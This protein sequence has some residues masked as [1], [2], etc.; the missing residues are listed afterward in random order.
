[1]A[2][3]GLVVNLDD[4]WPGRRHN[5]GMLAESGLGSLVEKMAVV[6]K[7]FR[8]YG[9]PAYP[10]SVYLEGPFRQS[11]VAFTEAEL[12]FDELMSAVRVSL[13]WEFSEIV[14]QVVF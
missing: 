5:S 4:P 12:L 8:I 3:K 1:M 14:Q 11:A 2:A 10:I 6:S 7:T 9:N 13:D